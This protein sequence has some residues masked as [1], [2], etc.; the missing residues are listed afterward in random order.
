MLLLLL[1]LLFLLYIY[2]YVCIGHREA[3]GKTAPKFAGR[4]H[5]VQGCVEFVDKAMDDDGL[6]L[7]FEYRVR[8]L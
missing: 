7:L 2:I 5:S 1:L 3:S 6:V 8:R 4:Y